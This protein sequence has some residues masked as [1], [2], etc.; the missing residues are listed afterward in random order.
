[1]PNGIGYQNYELE[2]WKT[3]VRHLA[4]FLGLSN[5]DLVKMIYNNEMEIIQEMLDNC[6]IETLKL[7]AHKYYS[8]YKKGDRWSVHTIA[9]TKHVAVPFKEIESIVYEYFSPCAKFNINRQAG[10]TYETD[11]YPLGGEKSIIQLKVLSGRNIK[12]SAIK[13]MV[14]V[15]V[16]QHLDSIRCAT[17]V[18]IKHM[19]K[20]EEKLR[21]SLESAQAHIQVIRET[22]KDATVRPMTFEQAS[23][24]IQDEIHFQIRTPE[25]VATIKELLLKRL[26]YEFSQRQDRLALG[27][28]LAY[29][30]NRER[31][32]S[33]TEHS[34]EQLQG[35]AHAA[36]TE[37]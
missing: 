37:G 12:T 30:A 10:W 20:W 34:R 4:S 9:S 24:W 28:T 26:E 21:H 11:L 27:K 15:Q 36:I 32:E 33:F 23:K 16:G 22:Y 3:G 14:S 35:Y 7:D 31:D 13:V 1:M 25:K 29:V 18:P 5:A 17:Y 19:L 2:I 8:T 6:D